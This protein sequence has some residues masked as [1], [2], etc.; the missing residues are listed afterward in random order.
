MV[1]TKTRD[2]RIEELLAGS[3][4][5]AV[6]AIKGPSLATLT[7]PEAANDDAS[8][9][10]EDEGSKDKKVR[11]R[12]SRLNT[13]T[14]ELDDLRT[15]VSSM[16][17]S[18][19]RIA[20]LEAQLASGRNQDDELPEWWK[21]AYG[22]TDISKQGYKNQQRVMREEM[23]R[24]LQE[25]EAKQEA[26]EQERTERFQSIEQ[27]FDDQMD[28]LENSL[29][30]D[31]TDTQK[32]ELLNLVE[33]YSPTDKNGKYEAYMSVEKAYELWSKGQGRDAGK[34]EMARI[35]GSQSSGGTVQQS[36]PE[37]PSWGDWRKRFGN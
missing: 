32:V 8:D 19:Q 13:L 27:S 2:E 6:S 20:A 4:T 1:E 26:A 37:R 16:S 28:E 33:D 22:D 29:G 36:S 24:A 25:E 14:S 17:A 9:V 31:L 10:N 5:D 35:A 12:A 11:I 3:G 7:Q 21:E 23:K 18:E 34:Q 15:K 30:R